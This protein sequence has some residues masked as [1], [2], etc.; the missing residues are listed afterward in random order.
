MKNVKILTVQGGAHVKLWMSFFPPDCLSRGIKFLISEETRAK[1]PNRSAETALKKI[2]FPF[3]AWRKRFTTETHTRSCLLLVFTSGRKGSLQ[4]R[5]MKAMF[6]GGI[7]N[8]YNNT[9]VCFYT[10]IWSSNPHAISGSRV[11]TVGVWLMLGRSKDS[12]G[13]NLSLQQQQRDACLCVVVGYVFVCRERQQSTNSQ[14][15]LCVCACV[16]V[17]LRLC[18]LT[19]LSP[20]NLFNFRLVCVKEISKLFWFR[21][22]KCNV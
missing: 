18:I 3:R 2:W 5:T 4:R 7:A 8:F 9:H 16:S 14:C 19:K 17:C 1:E 22:L 10:V 13:D 6:T 21:H 12:H 11:L 15:S 20:Q